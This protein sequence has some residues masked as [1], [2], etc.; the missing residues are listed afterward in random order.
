MFDFDRVIDRHGSWST[1][2]DFVAD[3][4]G[5]DDLLPFTIS[6]MDIPT[7]P[8][9]IAALQQRVAHGIFG[10]SRWQHSDF[11]EAISGWYQQRFAEKV[12]PRQIVY[13]PSVIY[14][15]AQM[16]RHWSQ[17]GDGVLIHTPAYDAFYKVIE[18]NQ[19]RVM[20]LPLNRS[21]GLWQCDMAAL[22]AL[23]ADPQCKILLLC[24]PHNPTGKVWHHRELEQMAQLCARYQVRVI[25]DEIHMDMVMGDAQHVPWSRV[26]QGRWALFTSAS[27]SF[28]VP[29][30]TGAYG[31]ISDEVDRDAWF[32]ALK[33]A[34][35]LSSPALLAVAAHI[36]AY[37]HGAEWLDALRIYL[38]DN[39]HHV[40][41]RL[42]AAF[43]A[44]NWQPPQA[45]YLAWIDL[46]P[47]HIDEQRLQQVLTE[48]YKVAI[49]PGS[50]YGPQC[51][52]WLRFNVGCPRSK[53][54]EG[55]N[56]LIAAL[57]CCSACD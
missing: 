31:L 39:L 14:M 29:G 42:N 9:V 43:P 30:L 36:A 3:R 52:G 51:R 7:A 23:L 17:P 15:V 47:L 19:R 55:L 32:Q 11:L 16:I 26:G 20:A 27:K 12:D 22:D 48:Q 49:M 44:L 13:G 35:G 2:W 6:D 18:G 57:Q 34:D 24:S 56:R 54:D 33:N 40:A 28:N 53:V 37:R 38:R 46:N 25:S 8:A 41:R 21:Q 5:H 10:Y 4:F 50:T 1:Q 45:T